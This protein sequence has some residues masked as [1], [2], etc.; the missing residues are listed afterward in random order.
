MERDHRIVE[1]EYRHASVPYQ[2]QWNIINHRELG[3]VKGDLAALWAH[4]ETVRDGGI[5]TEPF[6]SPFYA[7]ASSLRFESMSK[8]QLV[9]L[10]KRL[11]KNG[12]IIRDLENELVEQIRHYHRELGDNSYRA[13]HSILR[14]FLSHDTNAIAVEVPVWSTKHSISGHIDLVRYADGAIQVCDYKPGRLDKTA[15]RFTKSIPQVAA[16]GEMMAHR[17]AVPLREALDASRLPA[18]ECCI[19][20]SHSCWKFGAELFINLLASEMISGV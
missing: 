3:K 11:M 10:R 17:L 5:P 6:S 13:N 4:L 9:G 1:R 20:D 15:T 8:A 16:Y 18:I 14:E 2:F 12:Y 7:R 19:F